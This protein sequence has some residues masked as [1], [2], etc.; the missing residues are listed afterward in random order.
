MIKAF[1]PAKFSNRPA[2]FSNRLCI[3]LL[4]VASVTAAVASASVANAAE[5]TVDPESRCYRETE[6]VLLSGSGFSPN[7][8]VNFTR[9][10]QPIEVES[11]IRADG[12]GGISVN[13][14][15]RGVSSGRR[16]FRYAAIDSVNPANRAT[17]P[18]TVTATSVVITPDEGPPD[19]IMTIRARGFFGGTVLW[20]HIV[21]RGKQRGRNVRIGPVKG[22]CK[23]VRVKR[24]LFRADVAL[25][26]YDIQFDTFRT[27]RRRRD[28]ESTICIGVFPVGD[29]QSCKR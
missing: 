28:V 12:E 11:P 22:A 20:A 27:Y 24:R 25:G 19:R 5:L 3:S 10:G 14:T 4:C 17:L 1:R 21:R 29:E 15:L 7:E 23:R 18:M 9:D 6:T 16:V 8:I 2:K 13:L 26:V